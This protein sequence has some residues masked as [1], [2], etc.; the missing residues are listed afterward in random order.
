[1]H[2]RLALSLTLPVAG[3]LVSIFS[4]TSTY[5]RPSPLSADFPCPAS[6]LDTGARPTASSHGRQR[7]LSWYDWCIES[8]R[9][10]HHGPFQEFGSLF[11]SQL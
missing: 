7:Q 1:M 10:R 2:S 9:K 4:W 5:L 8:K 6:C 3:Q 11:P